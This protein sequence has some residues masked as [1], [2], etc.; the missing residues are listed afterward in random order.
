LSFS[1]EPIYQTVNFFS[2]DTS[3]EN[4]TSGNIDSGD[5]ITGFA[6]FF[7]EDESIYKALVIKISNSCT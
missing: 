1:S 2:L 4:L 3:S 7:S 6:I 5:F